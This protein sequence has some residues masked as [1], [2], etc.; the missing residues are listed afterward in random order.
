MRL[1]ACLLA[2][3]AVAVGESSGELAK[4][5]AVAIAKS[6]GLSEIVPRLTDEAVQGLAQEPL[7]ARSVCTAAAHYVY[8][9]PRGRKEWEPLVARVVVLGQKAADATPSSADALGACGEAQLCRLRLAVVLEQPTKIEDW[10]AAADWFVKAD[11][12][13]GG[14]GENLERAVVV[15]REGAA[16]PG[17]DSA[18]LNGRVEKTC[19]D[20]A[21]RY[22]EATFFRDVLL[23]R[24]LAK[25]EEQIVSDKR[26]A[27][28][29]LTDFLA[30]LRPKVEAKEP[31][32]VAATAYT[33]AVS[34]ARATKGLGVKADYI[35]RSVNVAASSL[36]LEMPVS[37][38][39]TYDNGMIR[40]YDRRGDRVRTFSFDTYSWDTAYHIGS[41][42]FGG[43]NLKGLAQL[44]E[45]NAEEMVVKIT[46]R[47][48]PERRRLNRRF[49]SAIYF[50][51]SGFDDESDFLRWA[52]YYVKTEKRMSV[53][54]SYLEF[55]DV[56]DLDAE[57]EWVLESIRE[58]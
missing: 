39:W 50:E 21:G 51:V 12:I 57:A 20:G 18:T 3:A 16:A 30:E 29:T 43:D 17:M 9:A 38:R 33:N 31:D 1:L 7:L 2:T 35:T 54:V 13:E 8:R 32:L 45:I 44:D 40:Q 52:N 46:K 58:P 49:T 53:Q 27:Q 6:A 37:G 41:T 19:E 26:G 28:K 34:V 56:K 11:G 42:E 5:V 48:K 10:E 23:D 4:D 55:R 22:G 36:V 25:I 47:K 15:L 14:K 24:R